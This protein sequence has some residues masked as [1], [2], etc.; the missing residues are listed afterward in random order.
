MQVSKTS[1]TMLVTDVK[2]GTNMRP[3]GR[4]VL[5]RFLKV[6]E[7]ARANR[8]KAT[9]ETCCFEHANYIA[10]VWRSRKQFLTS[11]C[12][13]YLQVG[14]EWMEAA[15]KFGS[16]VVTNVRVDGLTVKMLVIADSCDGL[17]FYVNTNSPDIAHSKLLSAAASYS[18]AGV[19]NYDITS[20]LCAVNV[21]SHATPSAAPYHM[22]AM[23]MNKLL[24]IMDSLPRAKITAD[25]HQHYDAGAMLKLLRNN[26]A[27]PFTKWACTRLLNIRDSTQSSMAGMLL[28]LATLPRRLSERLLATDIFDAPS[29][30]VYH[31]RA[32]AL[33][34]T[35]KHMANLVDEELWQLFEF[36]VLVNRQYNDVDWAQEKENRVRPKLAQVPTDYIFRECL[37]TFKSAQFVSKARDCQYKT[38][39]FNQFW[40][41]RWEWATTGAV[42]TQY[43]EL[44]KQFE[45]KSRHLRNKFIAINSLSNGTT[46]DELL[47]LH[48]EIAAKPSTKYEWGKVRAIYGTDLLSYILYEFVFGDCEQHLPADLP[49]GANANEQH[50]ARLLEVVDR[51]GMSYC[52]DF[53]DFNSQH[54][55]EAMSAVLEAY[56]TVHRNAMS[57]D[58]RR[59]ARWCVEALKTQVVWGTNVGLDTY[60]TEGTLFSGWRLTTFVNTM[61]NRCYFKYIAE[62]SVARVNGS[63]HSG[64][65]VYCTIA[66]PSD[67]QALICSAQEVNIRL[68]LTKCSLGSIAEF[69]R[70]DRKNASNKQYVARN[71][72]TVVH[73]RTESQQH[74]DII[75]AIKSNQTRLAEYTS[76]CG[77]EDISAQLETLYLAKL[78]ADPSWGD[79]DVATLQDVLS[80]HPV[81]GGVDK[82]SMRIPT[83]YYETESNIIYE[84]EYP[85]SMPGVNAYVDKLKHLV[86]NPMHIPRIKNV[87]NTA[88]KKVI[89]SSKTRITGKRKENIEDR[90]NMRA[91]YKC[92]AD[93]KHDTRFGKAR[94]VG[95]NVVSRA[96]STKINHLCNVIG[97]RPNFYE[98]L[99][100][101]V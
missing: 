66:A 13:R 53:E 72:A 87:I 55:T 6:V 96:L 86:T 19:E 74:G 30:S 68:S 95:V 35:F 3:R 88:T 94:L 18:H 92:Y 81:Y 10:V 15:P 1:Y 45:Y 67:A 50:I 46:L 16:W 59:A 41:T 51:E 78:S 37:S 60:R 23:P 40:E 64:D 100:V 21:F 44:A 38:K 9:V 83:Y 79:I 84:D 63:L 75:E 22:T 58:Q 26:T 24:D 90:H 5:P 43:P 34:T 71:I 82:T 11:A 54:S 61:L 49:I 29:L 93:Y 33:S 57:E 56:I 85:D 89:Y 73:G 8:S 39:D 31:Q 17:M 99:S 42:F 98:W 77:R 36:E 2:Q 69:L 12:G 7:K 48:P 91:L 80:L 25:H 14:S 101:L 32:K 65:D 47:S 52:L 97:E 4:A 62:N 27:L 76:R 70:V 20:P 28:W